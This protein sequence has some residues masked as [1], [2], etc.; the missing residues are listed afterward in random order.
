MTSFVPALAASALETILDR[1]HRR[2]QRVSADTLREIFLLECKRNI[3]LLDLLDGAEDDDAPWARAV[4]MGLETATLERILTDPEMGGPIVTELL[5]DARIVGEGGRHHLH[6]VYARA[7]AVQRLAVL[8]GDSAAETP[9]ASFRSQVDPLHR[10][11]VGFVH[12]LHAAEAETAWPVHHAA[13]EDGAQ[14]FTRLR[15]YLSRDR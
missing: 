7:S 13:R 6:S 2:G 8:L 3:K 11:Y 12:A 9:A 14:P 5:S 15:A 1:V 10:A 4:V